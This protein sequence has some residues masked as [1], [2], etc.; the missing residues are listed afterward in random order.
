M[1]SNLRTDFK[2]YHTL[3][4]GEI[5][6]NPHNWRFEEGCFAYLGF[7]RAESFEL[8]RRVEK[9]LCC[10]LA[11][12]GLGPVGYTWLFVRVKTLAHLV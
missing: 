9:R 4:S 6:E 8:G 10:L 3:D 1:G 7:S 11:R 5:K 2:R 12:C